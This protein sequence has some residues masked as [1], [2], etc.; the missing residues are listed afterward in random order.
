MYYVISVIIIQCLY[1]RKFQVLSYVFLFSEPMARCTPSCD[2]LSQVG[3]WEL[4]AWHTVRG[5]PSKGL[6]AERFSSTPGTHWGHPKA[7]LAERLAQVFELQVKGMFSKSSGSNAEILWVY[8]TVF[9]KTHLNRL[10]SLIKDWSLVQWHNNWMC[11]LLP[12]TTSDLE[13]VHNHVLM[14]ASKCFSFS[15]P[16]YEASTLLAALDYN[17]HNQRPPQVTKEGNRVYV[18][19]YFSILQV[20]V[21]KC[22]I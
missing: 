15:A 11:L 8:V 16:V 7:A 14:Y 19:A 9:I 3:F 12:R 5:S 1:D 10:T 18:T 21:C 22:F 13:T 20:F 4:P 6:D 17:H 2:R